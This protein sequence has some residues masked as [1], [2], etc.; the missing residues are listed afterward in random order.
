IYILLFIINIFLESDS[1]NYIMGIVGIISLF[2]AFKDTNIIY[3]LLALIFL[4]CSLLLYLYFNLLIK[5]I[6][7]Y[8]TSIGLLLSLLYMIPYINYF[9]KVGRYEKHLYVLLETNTQNLYQFYWKAS[10]TSYLLILF[11]FF[12]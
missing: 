6:P 9:I 1:F 2:A 4:T 3:K 11:I 5:N 7:Y 8:F 10:I 12:S